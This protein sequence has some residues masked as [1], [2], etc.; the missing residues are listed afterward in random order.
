[1]SHF[2]YAERFGP[3]AQRRNNIPTG[4][5][6]VNRTIDFT[7]VC[8]WLLIVFMIIFPKSGIKMENIPVTT[9]YVLICMMAVLASVR[10]CVAPK[11]G[12]ASL[13]ALALCAPFASLVGLALLTNG[14]ASQGAAFSAIMSFIL[15]P[16]IFFGLF[17]S[18]LASMRSATVRCSI[19]FA[20][21]I[22]ALYGIFLFLLKLNTGTYFEVPYL[23]VNA[24]DTGLLESTKYIQRG[25]VFKLISTYN[26]GNI[27]GV[28][29]LLL[30]PLYL[31]FERSR[32]MAII[33]IAALLLTLSRS[34][35]IGL[36]FAMGTLGLRKRLTIRSLLYLVIGGVIMMLA[37]LFLVYFIDQDMGFLM[38]SS[39]G[40]R[41]ETLSSINSMT[42]MLPQQVDMLP[43]IVYA[44]IVQQY[45]MLGLCDFMLLLAAPILSARVLY[46]RFSEVQARA[47]LG[48]YTYMVVC[49]ADGA[50]ML[51]PVLTI[52]YFVAT[53]LL[54]APRL[55]GPDSN[56]SE[57]RAFQGYSMKAARAATTPVTPPSGRSSTS[58]SRSR[59]PPTIC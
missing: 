40:G 43:E 54:E 57:T 24:D 58:P 10:F 47:A 6:D 35:W 44:G 36:V 41:A 2:D 20:L 39:L 3:R 16:V 48:I 51:I 56:L 28:S 42:L 38:D 19:V 4:K 8:Y 26:N 14:A 27:L 29:L 11:I 7:S 49:F 53:I 23:T 45:G 46:R 32:V 9:G 25:E 22:V 37:M 59:P 13:L 21:R 15:L 30:V 12:T 33:V 34:V 17:S 1:M 5:G 31:G 50:I 52:F 55:F 18:L